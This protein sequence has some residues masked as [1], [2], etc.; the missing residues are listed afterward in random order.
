MKVIILFRIQLIL[1]LYTK[2]ITDTI[3]VF[4]LNSC[5]AMKCP[6]IY[7]SILH[8]NQHYVFYVFICGRLNGHNMLLDNFNVWT[9]RKY[10]FSTFA[11]VSHAQYILPWLQGGG[12]SDVIDNMTIA[13]IPIP[14]FFHPWAKWDLCPHGAGRKSTFS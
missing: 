2:N 1:M 9:K 5:N 7:Q 8:R 4:H 14:V 12:N 3:K 10:H 11:V 6:Q 13:M